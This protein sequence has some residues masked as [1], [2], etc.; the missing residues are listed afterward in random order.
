MADAE[1]RNQ[2]WLRY[3]LPPPDQEDMVLR[4]SA[5]TSS[6][7]SSP[8]PNPTSSTALAYAPASPSEPESS[9]A[10]TSAPPLRRLL[11]ETSDLIESPPFTQILTLL[12][13]TAFSR[14]VDHNIRSE[15]FKLPPLSPITSPSETRI[16][17]ITPENDPAKATTKLATI[18]AVL[19]R[20]AH[21][22]GHGLPNEYAQAMEGVTE[23][24][25]FAALIFTEGFE[26]DASRPESGNPPDNDGASELPREAVADEKEPVDGG[27]AR[28]GDGMVNKA[29]ARFEGVWERVTW[30]KGE[31]ERV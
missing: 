27:E 1:I 16:T 21:A 11:D 13:D 2:R 31:C 29:W 15:A 8:P 12:L 18:L 20:Q 24:E 14:L 23:M 28:P 10:A 4:E 7:S 9:T 30:R 19:T 6:P 17:E 5:M 26:L 22:I 3:L 25:A